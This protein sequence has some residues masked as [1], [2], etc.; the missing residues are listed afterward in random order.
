MTEEN[1]Y[2][3]ENANLIFTQN[4]SQEIILKKQQKRKSSTN[5]MSSLSPKKHQT[6]IKP[7]QKRK[8]KKQIEHD[9]KDDYIDFLTESSSTTE[10]ANNQKNYIIDCQM[11]GIENSFLFTEEKLNISTEQDKTVTTA[12]KEK[13]RDQSSVQTQSN[14]FDQ[15]KRKSTKKEKWTTPKNEKQKDLVRLLKDNSKKIIFVTG[16]AGTGKTLFATECGIQ[17]FL[18]KSIDKLIFTRPSVCVDEDLGYLPGTLEEKMSPFVRPIYDVLETFLNPKEVQ[19]LMEEKK[20]EISPLG[21]MRG[22]T[23]KNSWIVADEMQNSTVSQMKMLLTRIGE[24]SRLIITGDLEQYD[25]NLRFNGLEDFLNRL[26]SQKD[27]SKNI[28][29]IIFDK[30][31][32]QREEVVKEVL[33]IYDNFPI[34][35][36]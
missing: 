11:F 27:Y 31:D 28:D 15:K 17:N 13:K 4:S 14:E 22:R 30:Q 25:K 21:F 2:Q 34:N 19:N 16:P 10:N 8:N 6:T 32:I 35:N 9:I 20:I 1:I 3:P 12:T 26:N 33:H 36:R 7:K 24:N 23:F 18:N 5:P 29:F